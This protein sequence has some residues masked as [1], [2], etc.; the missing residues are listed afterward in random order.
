MNKRLLLR[1]MEK[2]S[3]LFFLV[4]FFI[5]EAHAS[6][7]L[8][9]SR[10]GDVAASV[11]T[12]ASGEGEEK[13]LKKDAE[14][15]SVALAAPPAPPPPASSLYTKFSEI[16]CLGP[17]PIEPLRQITKEDEVRGGS[18]RWV[19]SFKDPGSQEWHTRMADVIKYL[20][21]KATSAQAL[22]G[23]TNFAVAR[24]TF[25]KVRGFAEVREIP[26]F[27]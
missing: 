26:F 13:R 1:K 23:S 24:L 7:L 19:K 25:Q 21:R 16:M 2:F 22:P 15:V 20:N 18:R 17:M 5:C 4:L 10:D 14:S 8:K 6:S 12:V 9:R 27:L 3:F 11:E